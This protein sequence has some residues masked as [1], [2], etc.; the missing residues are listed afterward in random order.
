MGPF[1]GHWVDGGC[2]GVQEV[3][4]AE[5]GIALAA[6]RVE[7]AES[8][9]AARRAGPIAS[10]EHLRPLADDVASEM[11][12]RSTGQLEPD[13]GGLADRGRHV[14]DEPRR[15]EDDE[16]DPGPPGERREATQPVRH[17]C[18]TLD[19]RWEIDDEEVHG[20][21]GKERAGD[22][23]AFVG[24]A[25]GEDH[26]PLRPDAAGDRLHGIEG[27]REVH[28]GDDRAGG[29]GLRDEAQGERR[30]SAGE[31]TS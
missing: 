14:C 18:G 27:R 13:P 21:A 2:L 24:V 8:R 15:L 29:L 26:E 16:A 6:V 4:A 1:P 28:P 17:A 3:L 31:V 20:P 30:P 5:A 11:D 7:D 9:P 12:P 23:E 10:D 19:P 22:R 25:R